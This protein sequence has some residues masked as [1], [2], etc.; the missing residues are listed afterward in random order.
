M[1]NAHAR[2][3][4]PAPPPRESPEQFRSVGSARTWEGGTV[5]CG[6]NETCKLARGPTSGLRTPA[7]GPVAVRSRGHIVRSGTT[8][9][10]W[11]LPPR[12]P[13]TG[14]ACGT[15]SPSR[16]PCNLCPNDAARL[17]EVPLGRRGP[18]S[19]PGPDRGANTVDRYGGLICGALTRRPD[20]RPVRAPATEQVALDE[21]VT[22]V[23]NQVDILSN[24][25]HSSLTDDPYL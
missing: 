18:T 14:P 16:F 24:L 5:Y 2:G 22:P 17:P 3:L 23:L 10:S 7:H 25:S 12:T 21:A 1:R 20:S 13:H 11:Q 9:K 19:D 15:R 8:P 4:S 6:M